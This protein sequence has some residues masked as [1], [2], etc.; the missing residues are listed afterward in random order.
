MS[1]TRADIASALEAVD[2]VAASPTPPTTIV[3]GCAWPNWVST[4]WVNADARD[5]IWQIFVALPGAGDAATIDAGD[6]L[7]ELVGRAIW[8]LGQVTL[9]EPVLVQNGAN[10]GETLPALRFRLVTL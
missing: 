1:I 2:G 5:E 8:D 9:V 7:V 4:A 10:A 3:P 6:P